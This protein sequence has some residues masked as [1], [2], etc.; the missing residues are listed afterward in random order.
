MDRRTVIMRI[1]P[2][3]RLSELCGFPYF[4]ERYFTIKELL[5]QGVI[6][7]NDIREMERGKEI[8]K[9]IKAGRLQA[10]PHWDVYEE[11]MTWIG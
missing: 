2:S 10:K 4:V 3:K 11:L 1:E 6:T 8:Q 7:E 9:S 5:E